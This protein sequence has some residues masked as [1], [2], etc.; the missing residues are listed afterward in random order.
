MRFFICRGKYDIVACVSLDLRV[1]RIDLSF[2]RVHAILLRLAFFFCFVLFPFL[3]CVVDSNF[4]ACSLSTRAVAWVVYCEIL[5][6]GCCRDTK[7]WANFPS[8][9]SSSW[10]KKRTF[11]Q[12]LS[13]SNELFGFCV[14]L[15]T[16]QYR[17][18]S[19]D[20]F[21]S[22][23]KYLYFQGERESWVYL[24]SLAAIK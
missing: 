12:H 21:Y 1:G 3:K 13:I 15:Y 17:I 9:L 7:T 11:L 10:K 8:F 2:S 24:N 18:C 19:Q 16:S 6:E 23:T 4:G 5:N 22:N 20:W 14:S